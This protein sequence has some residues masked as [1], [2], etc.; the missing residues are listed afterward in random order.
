MIT[1][2]EILDLS[3]NFP[4]Q[5]RENTLYGL[6]DHAGLPGL[7][8]QLEKTQTRWSSLFQGSKDEGA[9]EVA[10]ILFAIEVRRSSFARDALLKWICQRG[11]N[12]SSLIFMA[13][14]LAM[15]DLSRRL[16]LRLDAQLPENVDVV[17]RFFDTRIFESVL[18]VLT[19][20]QK[21]Q[22]LTPACSWWYMDRKDNLQHVESFF[23][24]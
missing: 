11:A 12:S 7:C 4:A 6:A 23:F 14:P 17:L 10:P 8:S 5:G 21:R 22:F 9:L 16:A 20:E 13:S 2:Q 1:Y 3:L 15:E 18:T 24:S 19:E